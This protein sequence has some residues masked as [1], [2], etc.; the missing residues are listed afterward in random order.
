MILWDSFFV[1]LKEREKWAAAGEGSCY[2][3]LVIK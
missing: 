2:V 3:D 1:L